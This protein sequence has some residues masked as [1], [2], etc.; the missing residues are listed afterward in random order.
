MNNEKLENTVDLD[1]VKNY[2]EKELRFLAHPFFCEMCCII[3][4]TPD[5][6]KTFLNAYETMLYNFRGMCSKCFEYLNTHE[7]DEDMNNRIKIFENITQLKVKK[8]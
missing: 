4:G 8:K 1:Y 7:N 2:I 6:R 5:K 3:R